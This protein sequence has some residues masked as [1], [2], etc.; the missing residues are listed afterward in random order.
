MKVFN[1]FLSFLLVPVYFLGYVLGVVVR[2]VGN[3]LQ[4][5]REG[6]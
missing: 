6:F 2:I 4:D 5:G 3:G 1:E